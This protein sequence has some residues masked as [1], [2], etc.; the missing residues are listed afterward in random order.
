MLRHRHVPCVVETLGP[1]KN[2]ELSMTKYVRHA[3]Q[4][5]FAGS[6]ALGLLSL[7]AAACET[8]EAA[9]DLDASNGGHD[10]TFD[11][12]D[13]SVAQ[14]G[15]TDGLM[16]TDSSSEAIATD[17]TSDAIGTDATGP[18]SAPG[19]TAVDAGGASI[20]WSGGVF[21]SSIAL[22][23]NYV[24]WGAANGNEGSLWK[25][26]KGPCCE[27]PLLLFRR[28][29]GQ[30]GGIALDD[31]S[32]YWT[33]RY[34]AIDDAGVSYGGLVMRMPL[35]GGNP[36]V[37]ASTSSRLNQIAVQG[38]RVFWPEMY[39]I[40]M[41]DLDGGTPVTL[42]QGS[43]GDGTPIAADPQNVYWSDGPVAGSSVRVVA[44]SPLD[45]G[46]DGGPVVLADQRSGVF[47]SVWLLTLD[48]QYAYFGGTAVGRVALQ[49]NARGTHDTAVFYGQMNQ[50]FAKFTANGL[51]LDDSTI[52]WTDSF[53]GTV[54]SIS[55]D[56]GSLT[57]LASQKYVGVIAADATEVYWGDC[58]SAGVLDSGLPIGCSIGLLRRLAK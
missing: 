22:D 57:T 54:M 41:L 13:A 2:R 50:A 40:S 19:C 25:C 4:G 37:L 39:G 16:P 5:S 23:A 21:P 6:F 48:P 42:A 9:S 35:T 51:A 45:A 27:A 12:V 10:A 30:L 8:R 43:F 44:L 20:F 29:V 7:A 46:G 32:V 55:K 49:P 52:Y 47:G 18:D 15:Q 36:E 38:G 53:N 33:V 3:R 56:G 14:A 24:Y 28:S 31:A 11:D 26:L 17:A 1:A 58:V 34:S